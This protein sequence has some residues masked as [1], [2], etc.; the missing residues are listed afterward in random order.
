MYAGGS[1]CFGCSFVCILYGEYY[2]GVE[3]KPKGKSEGK[4]KHVTNG[5]IVPLEFVATMVGGACTPL[6]FMAIIAS[7]TGT[8]LALS[9]QE[10]LKLP[11]SDKPNAK[12]DLHDI[13]RM[14]LAVCAREGNQYSMDGAYREDCRPGVPKS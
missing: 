12:Y 14:L 6:E 11:F 9:L 3:G 5:G 10:G 7:D 2:A 13:Y 8:N 4:S 1:K